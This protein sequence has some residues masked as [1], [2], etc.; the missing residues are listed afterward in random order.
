MTQASGL[1]SENEKNS[2]ESVFGIMAVAE[3]TAADAM[4]HAAVP[5]HQGLESVFVAPFYP[6]TQQLGIARRRT[7]Q[8][9]QLAQPG[10]MWRHDNNPRR[11][12]RTV[13]YMDLSATRAMRTLFC[14]ADSFS[15]PREQSEIH[16]LKER[17]P[18]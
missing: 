16:F 14:H 1:A 18:P 2:L 8:T 11:G 5:R 15:A 12:T 3:Y 9:V 10:G 4:D 13:L 6:V 17:T 7:R